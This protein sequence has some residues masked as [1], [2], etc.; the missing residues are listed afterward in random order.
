MQKGLFGG[1]FDFNR[2]GKLDA[3]ERAAEFAFLNNMIEEENDDDS[4][5]DNDD[6]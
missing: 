6:F 1:V 4:N 3:I 5:E 2:D